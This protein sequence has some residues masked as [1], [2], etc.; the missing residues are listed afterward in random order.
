M[1]ISA[2]QH[3]TMYFPWQFI[4]MKVSLFLNLAT[5]R[6]LARGPEPLRGGAEVP[7]I[8]G[9]ILIATIADSR[10]QLTSGFMAYLL[11]QEADAM[12]QHP[13]ENFSVP[14]TIISM[15]ASTNIAI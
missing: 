15:H 7:V 9:R 12:K 14:E 11:S 10:Q 6:A 8:F 1:T 4:F 13:V 2:R 5:L 3:R